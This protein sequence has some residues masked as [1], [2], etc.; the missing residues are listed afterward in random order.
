MV[1]VFFPMS[2]IVITYILN[3][4]YKLFLEQKDKRFLK[5]T[6]GRYVA[7]KLIDDMYKNK[8]LPEL[9]GESG[10]RTAFFSDIESFYKLS[11]RLRPTELVEILN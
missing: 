6:F 9:G 8:K 7:P 4:G 3:L 5:D 10:I 11:S 2:S 1:P